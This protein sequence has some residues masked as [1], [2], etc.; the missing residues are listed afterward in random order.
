MNNIN[1]FFS[2]IPI[3]FSIIFLDK[4]RNIRLIKTEYEHQL[5]NYCKSEKSLL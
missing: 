1:S 4:Y 5:V 2:K 3:L